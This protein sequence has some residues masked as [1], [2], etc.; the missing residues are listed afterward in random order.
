LLL[1]GGSSRRSIRG[2][3]NESVVLN[4]GAVADCFRL[5]DK[6]KRDLLVAF[7]NDAGLAKND[8]VQDDVMHEAV[9]VIWHEALS[10]FGFWVLCVLELTG[11]K[12]WLC[13]GWHGRSFAAFDATGHQIETTSCVFVRMSVAPELD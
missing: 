2:F 10:V 3:A 7:L 1:V 4:E 13:L 12:L 6:R 8:F 11:I 9:S 5:A